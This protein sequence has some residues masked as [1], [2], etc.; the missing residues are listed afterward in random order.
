MFSNALI[1]PRS[2]HN[3]CAGNAGTKEIA[4]KRRGFSM[5]R[6]HHNS[7]NETVLSA[8]IHFDQATIPLEEICTNLLPA[9]VT[10]HCDCLAVNNISIQR[11][12]GGHRSP[13][14]IP[15][16]KQKKSSNGKR[17]DRT[18]CCDFGPGRRIQINQRR[19][20]EALRTKENSF[21]MLPIT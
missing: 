9:Q 14:S 11:K 6:M 13:T 19:S 1:I 18:G 7:W 17:H 21:P 5:T 2:C 15:S 10:S 12:L 3:Q 4:A 16:G 20:V 8:A